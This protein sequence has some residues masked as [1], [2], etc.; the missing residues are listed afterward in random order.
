MSADSDAVTV[1]LHNARH[2]TKEQKQRE[3]HLLDKEKRELADFMIAK[4]SWW[5]TTKARTLHEDD[6]DDDEVYIELV[7]QDQFERM[8]NSVVKHA[9]FDVNGT[10]QGEG[11]DFPHTNNEEIRRK[12]AKDAAH[13]FIC[14]SAPGYTFDSSKPMG[15]RLVRD[16][17]EKKEI[18]QRPE[19]ENYIWQS[20]YEHLTAWSKRAGET[21]NQ[22]VALRKSL[23]YIF[24]Q[25]GEPG[26]VFQK[27]WEVL[28]NHFNQPYGQEIFFP[29]Y[30][31][32]KESYPH[33]VTVFATFGKQGRSAAKQ[34]G[35]K[36]RFFQVKRS[37]VLGERIVFYEEDAEVEGKRLDKEPIGIREFNVEIWKAKERREN[38]AVRWD[39][40]YWKANGKQA[41]AGKKVLG[42]K[43][44]EG[45]VLDDLPCWD[46]EGRN[47]RFFR[48]DTAR[49]GTERNFFV[50]LSQPVL[51]PPTAP[52]EAVRTTTTEV[53][54]GG[55][56]KEEDAKEE[57]AEAEHKNDQDQDHQFNPDP[58]AG[59]IT[60]PPSTPLPLDQCP[61]PMKRRS[62]EQDSPKAHQAP[63]PSPRRLLDEFQAVTLETLPF[64][65]SLTT[66]KRSRT[67]ENPQTADTD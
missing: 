61:A 10:N 39:V 44:L 33:V 38:F 18:M 66:S 55:E 25:E 13:E 42:A 56:A 27:E 54:T 60:T 4:G 32:F 50:E 64:P 31:H 2:F 36:F 37:D 28:M 17:Q 3:D 45:V 43:F 57:E 11:N 29:S 40:V 49:A 34:H 46:V 5:D 30:L 8:C 24:C 62:R 20:A 19:A 65:P 21:E 47:V 41:W 15:W 22:Q 58:H 26:E 14:R 16:E 51:G 35:G 53:Q 63:Q 12:N 23:A 59:I 7:G 6:V 52:A 9:H 67:T 48:V 1:T